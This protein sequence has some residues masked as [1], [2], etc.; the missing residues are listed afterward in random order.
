MK[1]KHLLEILPIPSAEKKIRRALKSHVLLWLL[2]LLLSSC[3][4]PTPVKK[5][6]PKKDLPKFPAKTEKK[7]LP[8]P[9]HFIFLHTNDFHG[10][11]TPLASKRKGAVVFRGGAA[12]IA[13]YVRK[14]RDKAREEGSELI[15]VDAG[16]IFQGTPEGNFTRGKLVVEYLNHIGCAAMALGNHEF[17]YGES[18][19]ADLAKLARFPILCANLYDKKTQARPSYLQPYKIMER[20]GIKIALIGLITPELYL[21]TAIKWV[22]HLQVVPPMPMTLRM[23]DQVKEKG[24]QVI[25]ILSHMGIEE[26]RELARSV[27]GIDFIIGGHSHTQ[28]SK[29]L[30]I[31]GARIGQA[32]DKGQY[33]GR[34]EFWMDPKTKKIIRREYRLVPVT[35]ELGVDSEVVQ[36][37]DKYKPAIDKVM[38][39]RL[40]FLDKALKRN[41]SRSS[42]PLGNLMAD[43]MRE[44]T[45]ADIA[46]QNKGG[47]RANLPYGIIRYREVYQVAPFENMVITL[48]LTGKQLY[49]LFL[50]SLQKSYVLEVSGA[51]V[52]FIQEGKTVKISKILIGDKPLEMD[53]HYQIVTNSFLADGGDGFSIFRQGVKRKDRGIPYRKTLIQYIQDHNPLNYKFENRYILGGRPQKTPS[54]LKK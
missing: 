6:E 28:I 43:A 31:G 14:A 32:R 27:K 8:K 50:Q 22:K 40:G 47:I 10:Q 21:V 1:A 30:K 49:S 2:F 23:I 13:A 17:D 15:F 53:R 18:V 44:A 48:F 19:V 24:A 3:S 26:D 12:H 52:F 41:R 16:D 25:V 5:S 54:K 9:L 7:P 51:K 4:T 36:L 46:F 38:N 42:S 35:P 29:P 34:T 11:M 45:G 37:I 39:K 20:G 33:I